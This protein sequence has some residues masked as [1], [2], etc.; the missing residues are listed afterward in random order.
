MAIGQPHLL[1]CPLQT[2]DTDNSHGFF[3]RKRNSYGGS[4]SSCITSDLGKKPA[5]DPKE[6]KSRRTD[7][8][9][10]STSVSTFSFNGM[11]VTLSNA[12]CIQKNSWIHT[13]VGLIS[14]S[15]YLGSFD[16]QGNQGAAAYGRCKMR[17]LPRREASDHAMHSSASR[18]FQPKRPLLSFITGTH[19]NISPRKHCLEQRGVNL[20]KSAPRWSCV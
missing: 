13:Q 10:V 20:A 1:P 4:D 2:M 17:S 19:K 14:G 7:S 3:L 9:H 12:L 18:Q 11:P 6:V 5:R 16:G 8:M 15:A